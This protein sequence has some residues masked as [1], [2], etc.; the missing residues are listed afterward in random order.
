MKKGREGGRKGGREEGKRGRNEVGRK[1]RV[2]RKGMRLRR[3]EGGCEG[4]RKDGRSETEEGR[5]RREGGTA[6]WLSRV[7]DVIC[8]SFSTHS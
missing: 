4:R 1:V 2:V 6:L 3:K 8:I 5:K 7:R